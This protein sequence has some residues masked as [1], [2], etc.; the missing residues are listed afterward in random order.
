MPAK[1]SPDGSLPPANAKASGR[2]GRLSIRAQVTALFPL[3]HRLVPVRAKRRVSSAG[4]TANCATAL[5]NRAGYRPG[6]APVRA[7][8]HLGRAVGLTGV[9]ISCRLRNRDG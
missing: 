8:L 9:A 1:T 2:S 5:G 4:L 6:E 7:A 3:C